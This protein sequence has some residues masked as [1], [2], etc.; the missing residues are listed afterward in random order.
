[1]SVPTTTVEV[2]FDETPVLSGDAFTLDDSEMGVLNNPYFLLDGHLDFKDVSADVQASKVSRGRSRQLDKYAAGAATIDF[3]STTRKYDPLNESSP[4]YPYVTPRRYVR[5]RTNGVAVFAG[6]INTWSMSYDLTGLTYMSASASDSTTLLANQL[7]TEY[8]PDVELTGTRIN[9]IF[10]RPEIDFTATAVSIDAGTSTLGAFLIPAD[11]NAL[12]YLRQIEKS[13][14]GYL[15]ASANDTFTFKDRSTVLAQIGSV[16]FKDDGTGT[17]DYMTLDVETGDELLFNRI[18][19]QSVGAGVAQ[20][21]T[22]ATSISEYDISTLEATDLLNKATGEVASIA[23]LLLQQYKTPEIRFT[24][25]SQQLWAM[26]GV[27][28][29]LLLDLDLTDL[30]TV[31]KT[32]STG[33]PL[34]VTKY[35]LV[36]GI[37]HTITP[38]S[39]IIGFRFAS[40]NESGFI[41]DSGTFGL[42]DVGSVG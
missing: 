34:S 17:S 2:V 33:S 38:Q 10:A 19:A 16:S 12:G 40:L 24:G 41:L 15:F 8:T 5:I 20:V 25:I 14:Q 26:S 18:V 29:N 36:E 42:L 39:H 9:T 31:T 37:T 23:D 7:L 30:A 4:Y 22:D 6:L 35:V 1:M 13:E 28:Q 32:Y 11:T 27:N 21:A 3:V